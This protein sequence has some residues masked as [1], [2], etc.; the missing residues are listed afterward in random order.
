MSLDLYKIYR[1][2]SQRSRR[3]TGIEL[4]QEIKE[5]MSKLIYDGLSKD[6]MIAVT[7]EIEVLETYLDHKLKRYAS[8]IMGAI[9]SDTYQINIPYTQL[10]KRREQGNKTVLGKI[11]L[12]CSDQKKGQVKIGATTLKISKRE[13]FYQKRW[14]YSMSIDWFQSIPDPF[15]FESELKAI[16]K[17]NRV[18]GLTSGDSNEWYFG[19]IHAMS[20]SIEALL[21]L[22]GSAL[23][24][25]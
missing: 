1:M 10:H 23:R 14:G 19:D 5:S 22:R 2:Y 7:E 6:Q 13:Y 21:E 16:Y 11:Y 9:T 8:D 12:G 24:S 20:E 17:E 25:Q 15:S 4:F 18:A 3:D